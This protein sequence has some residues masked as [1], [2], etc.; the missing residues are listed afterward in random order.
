MDMPMYAV[1]THRNAGTF[2]IYI[3][4]SVYPILTKTK[5]AEQFLIKLLNIL[6]HEDP[7]RSSRVTVYLQAD[8]SFNRHSTG[9]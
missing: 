2:F 9:W 4:S 1:D 7:V 3:F 8:S 6:F 5:I